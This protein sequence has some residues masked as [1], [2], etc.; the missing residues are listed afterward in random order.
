[1]GQGKGVDQGKALDSGV[2]SSTYGVGPYS[3]M[4]TFQAFSSADQLIAPS[5]SACSSATNHHITYNGQSYTLERYVTAL[6]ADQVLSGDGLISIDNFA[7]ILAGQFFDV[8]TA[9]LGS[10]MVHQ[11]QIYHATDPLSYTSSGLLISPAANTP[12]A[13]IALGEYAFSKEQSDMG[14]RGI[15]LNFGILGSCLGVYKDSG[16][17]YLGD[18]QLVLVLP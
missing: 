1:M 18:K 9:T 7:T 12:V 14:R 11:G 6:Y 5:S 3:G 4:E 8:P 2:Y 13:T 17:Q 15:E 16:G 10:V